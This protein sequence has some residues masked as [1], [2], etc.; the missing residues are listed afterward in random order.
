MK[1]IPNRVLMMI[2]SLWVKVNTNA[3][4]QHSA[5]T[6]SGNRQAVLY[7]AHSFKSFPAASNPT[8]EITGTF[9]RL[10]ASRSAHTGSE[11]STSK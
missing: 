10:S 2:T 5:F 6:E 11:R 7:H 3:S 9:R 1:T 4:I 8:N